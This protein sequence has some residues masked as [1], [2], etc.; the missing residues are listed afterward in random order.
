MSTALPQHL[1]QCLM[2]PPNTHIPQSAV[3]THRWSPAHTGELLQ[4]SLLECVYLWPPT[5]SPSGSK[6]GPH[7]LN[8]WGSHTHSLSGTHASCM[9]L[10]MLRTHLVSICH[11]C[12]HQV[13][14]SKPAHVPV[15]TLMHM[16]QS[17]RHTH[18]LHH[19]QQTL[20]EHLWFAKS[21][22]R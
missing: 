6:R 2:P 16:S 5:P 1:K 7:C 9:R 4:L 20:C 22:S 8:S 21:C 13:P 12:L 10:L 19:I 17:L 18:C 14:V 3:L 11:P 15:A